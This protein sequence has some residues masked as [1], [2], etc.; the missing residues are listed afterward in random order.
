M[1][2]TS[3]TQEYEAILEVLTK[4]NEG[5]VKADSSILQPLFNEQSTSFGVDDGKLIGGQMQ[6]MFDAIDNEL[7]PSPGA[8][9]Q[10]VRIDVVGDAASVRIDMNNLAGAYYVD[11]FNLLKIEGKWTIMSKVFHTKK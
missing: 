7:K 10:I 3:C 6:W 11:F 9:P 5:C 8:Q 1:N 4:Y 2:T